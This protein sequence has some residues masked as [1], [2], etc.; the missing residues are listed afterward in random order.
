[1]CSCYAKILP[2]CLQI[3][4]KDLF[5]FHR[6]WNSNFNITITSINEN[7]DCLWSIKIWKLVEF[8]LFIFKIIL[9]CLFLY[10]NPLFSTIY[11]E[12]GVCHFCPIHLTHEECVWN[13]YN[14]TISKNNVEWL[15]YWSTQLNEHIWRI[16]YYV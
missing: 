5:L 12:F 9:F 6:Y 10:F 1:M 13:C 14:I 15:H 16:T 8:P 4:S 7:V 2:L 3:Y 11:M